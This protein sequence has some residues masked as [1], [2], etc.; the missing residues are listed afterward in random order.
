[1]RC[2]R[3]YWRFFFSPV[4]KSERIKPKFKSEK[5]RTT[6]DTDRII[7]FLVPS[8]ET[9]FFLELRVVTRLAA[10]FSGERFFTTMFG[11]SLDAIQRTATPKLLFTQSA[12]MNDTFFCLLTTSRA[13]R[14]RGPTVQKITF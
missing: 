7:K 1:M 12:H 4:L 8:G 14:C 2:F 3:V 5:S 11:L 13:R 9:I 10:S 6:R